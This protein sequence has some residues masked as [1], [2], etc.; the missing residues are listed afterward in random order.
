MLRL[1]AGKTSKE[2][3]SVFGTGLEKGLVDTDSAQ[4]LLIAEVRS[5]IGM[6]F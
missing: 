4:N 2:K 5:V 6:H 3:A 1:S